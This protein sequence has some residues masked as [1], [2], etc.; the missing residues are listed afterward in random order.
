MEETG[1]DEKEWTDTD[2]ANQ[3]VCIK[4]LYVNIDTQ[5]S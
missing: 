2:Q 3:P 5:T 1:R 4:A